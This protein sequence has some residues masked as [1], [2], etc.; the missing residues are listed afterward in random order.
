[1][2]LRAV[3]RGVAE[4]LLLERNVVARVFVN[5]FRTPEVVFV[6][7]LPEV[8]K[9]RERKRNPR[10]T[11]TRG[12]PKFDF[13][14]YE[15]ARISPIVQEWSE[16]TRSPRLR[17]LCRSRRWR[18]GDSEPQRVRFPV[19]VRDDLSLVPEKRPIQGLSKYQSSPK[20]KF[21]HCGASLPRSQ[22]LVTSELPDPDGPPCPFATVS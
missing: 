10:V 6:A 14:T 9:Q 7:A 16:M 4:G 20:E 22:R 18:R 11:P 19:F 13:P 1:M 3:C 8:K 12:A 17:P 2:K 5:S 21:N 15:L